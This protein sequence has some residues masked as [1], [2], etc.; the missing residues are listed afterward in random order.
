MIR[1]TESVDKAMILINNHKTV[2]ILYSS[3]MMSAFFYIAC[4]IS[5]TD[6][7]CLVNDARKTFFLQNWSAVLKKKVL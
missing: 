7:E 3:T 5:C 4:E 6:N 2:A 1:P